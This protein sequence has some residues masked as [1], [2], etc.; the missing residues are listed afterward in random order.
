MKCSGDVRQCGKK[1]REMHMD[2]AA[3]FW[4]ECPQ[5]LSDYEFRI[6]RILGEVMLRSQWYTILKQNW[7]NSWNVAKS[8]FQCLHS[9]C[10][11]LLQLS[12]QSSFDFSVSPLNP[13]PVASLVL[14]RYTQS[15]RKRTNRRSVAS[16][17]TRQCRPPEYAAPNQRLCAASTEDT[18][19]T[20]R[21]FA[22]NW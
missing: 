18:S 6:S 2:P 9:I 21:A 7:E 3:E 14:Y 20:W 8:K 4:S 10:Q 1:Q 12:I 11:G 17:R 5:I 16:P 13:G 15:K 22:A 19:A